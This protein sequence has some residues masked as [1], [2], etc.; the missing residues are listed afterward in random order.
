MPL[1]RG[2]TRPQALTG[3]NL[4]TDPICCRKLKGCPGGEGG[5]QA[6]AL[7]SQII[8]LEDSI[9]DIRFPR[10]GQIPKGPRSKR[11]RNPHDRVRNVRVFS[12]LQH[13]SKRGRACSTNTPINVS[14]PWNTLNPSKEQAETKTPI[15]PANTPAALA[16]MRHIHSLCHVSLAD[17][18]TRHKSQRPR[19][20]RYR[21]WRNDL[22]TSFALRNIS[23][24]RNRPPSDVS[25]L[26][27]HSLY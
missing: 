7:K 14:A 23:G 18:E 4:I 13:C 21:C 26:A 6:L 27:F 10:A 2:G 20:R 15:L 19:A 22:P 8:K 5:W 25:N 11:M 16:R 24:I 9:P 17:Q 1:T 12:V 3:G